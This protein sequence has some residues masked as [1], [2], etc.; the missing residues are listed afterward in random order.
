MQEEVTNRESDLLVWFAAGFLVVLI[1]KL[2]LAIV[3]DLYSD[4]IFYWWASTRLSL[5]YSDL[6]FMTALLVG[7]G[8]GFDA[9]N[10]LQVRSLFLVLGS[11][12]PFLVYW[13]AE[14][15]YGRSSALWS[16]LL[17]LCLPLGGFMGLLAVPDVPLVFFG[18]L[19]I[20]SFD[21]ALRSNHW[22]YW[23]ATGIFV[24]LGLCTHYRFFLYPLAAILY[25]IFFPPARLQWRNRRFWCAVMIACLGLIPILWFNLSNQLSSA[26]FYLVERHPWEFQSTGLLHIFKQAGLVTPPL[27]L[28]LLLTM[29]HLYK[30]SRSGSSC[31]ALL[32]SF[33]VTNLSVYLILAP[34]TDAN[35]T[36]IHWPLS[37]YFPLLVAVPATLDSLRGK[38]TAQYG[39]NSAH[40]LI[41]SVPAIGFLGTLVALFGV[42]SQAYQEPLQKL[43]GTG[44]L[45]N[46]MAG[47]KEFSSHTEQILAQNIVGS[48]P[49]II[50]DNYY[51]A[52]QAEFA[53]LGKSTLT[54]DQ[55]KAVRDGRITQL[56]LWNKSIADLNLYKGQLA[57]YISEDSTLEIEDAT[58]L[59]AFVCDISSE[60]EPL[61]QLS[62]FNGDK[63]F[64]FY[65]ISEIS[66]P[67]GENPASAFPCPY[68]I[69]AWIDQP[70]EDDV[71]SGQVNV[72]GWAYSEDVGVAGVELLIDGNRVAS[73][74]YGNNRE[75]VVTVRSVRNDP[76]LPDLGFDLQYDSTLLSNGR[77][78]MA[79]EVSNRQGRRQIYGKRSIRVSN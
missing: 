40:R 56:Q 61:D 1:I 72:S 71:L 47:W 75:D 22:R 60:V 17:T 15:L 16:A 27:Y 74:E 38:F 35:S 68:P 12:L 62:L 5:A 76:N 37:G 36:S 8:S 33:A 7:L 54:L 25:L 23:L 66:D 11:S 55:D 59:M 21:R 4:E 32:L 58:D 52:A 48:E 24:A 63:A 31:A 46:K 13:L 44:V 79:I 19:S 30:Q 9:A 64:S 78:E 41:I 10:A 26:S 42:G 67:V 53:G 2:Y 3:L 34:W 57:L 73:A 14:P 50:T 51:T 69:H 45:S 49:L 77:H 20:G 70:L 65:L 28:V 18:L 6:P 39:E 29:W 43:I